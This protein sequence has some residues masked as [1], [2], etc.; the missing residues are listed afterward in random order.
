MEQMYSEKVIDHFMNPRNV[1]VIKDANGIGEAGDPSCGD[2]TVI[3][4]KV[5]S[6]YIIE[7]IKFQVQGCGGAIATSSMTT[8]LAKGKHI[9]EAYIITDK[10]IIEALDGLPE[11]KH[12][13]SVLGATALR[14]AI[15]DFKK[16]LDQGG[17][18]EK[19]G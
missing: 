6:N 2:Y 10:D 4:L 7:D 15:Y 19:Q 8:E 13:C 1:G 3:F 16:R 17:V 5:N 12:H 14:N 11:E 18:N 9:L